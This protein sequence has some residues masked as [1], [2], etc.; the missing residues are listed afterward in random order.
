MIVKGFLIFDR[1]ILMEI[2]TQSAVQVEVVR[3]ACIAANPGRDGWDLC[4]SIEQP[5]IIQLSPGSD[6][7]TSLFTLQKLIKE[8]NQY[9]S[10]YIS[11]RINRPITYSHL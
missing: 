4:V 2:R 6:P 9:R 3:A 7:L 8:R 10:R 11:L 1:P 5:L